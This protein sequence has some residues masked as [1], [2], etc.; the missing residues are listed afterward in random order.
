MPGWCMNQDSTVRMI[1]KKKKKAK[2]MMIIIIKNNADKRRYLSLDSA[3]HDKSKLAFSLMISW[4]KMFMRQ[5]W[6]LIEWISHSVSRLISSDWHPV[7]FSLDTVEIP[8]FNQ[9]KA[10]QLSIT[11]NLRLRLAANY[12]YYQNK[13]S[14]KNDSNCTHLHIIL[15]TFRVSGCFTF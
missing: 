13:I 15:F 12:S 1:G 14:M 6:K 4:W 9:A 11:N 7:V 5:R 3:S 8:R 10:S 2:K